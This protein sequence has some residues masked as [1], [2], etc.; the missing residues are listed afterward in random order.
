[1]NILPKLAAGLLAL[2]PT[3]FVEAGDL[4]TAQSRLRSAIK[5]KEGTYPKRKVFLDETI[6]KQEG[7]RFE[8][9]T[10][11]VDYEGK[12]RVEIRDTNGSAKL[13]CDGAEREA[14]FLIKDGQPIVYQYTP[15]LN[16]TNFYEDMMITVNYTGQ[17]IVFT[18]FDNNSHPL[19]Q[20]ICSQTGSGAHTGD[21]LT[22][23]VLDFEAQS[24]SAD[25]KKLTDLVDS[26]SDCNF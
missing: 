1:M 13:F 16:V 26:K 25:M 5:F 3:T 18:Y 11:C 9:Q 15:L 10:R 19:A 20:E 4:E 21:R 22:L 7:V 14:L 2:L 12:G 6:R 24:N 23:E 8:Y 17:E